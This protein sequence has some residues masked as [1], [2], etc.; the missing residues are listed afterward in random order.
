ME[1]EVGRWRRASGQRG[2]VRFLCPCPLTEEIWSSL[3]QAKQVSPPAHDCCTACPGCLLGFW[4][5]RELEAEAGREEGR[6]ESNG[7][8]MDMLKKVDTGPL[9]KVIPQSPLC[10]IRAVPLAPV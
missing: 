1:R 4:S 10:H 8:R 2:L 3:V 5:L 7:S 6:D 9:M